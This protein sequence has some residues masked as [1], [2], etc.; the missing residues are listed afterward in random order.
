MLQ[1]RTVAGSWRKETR[2]K[3]TEPRDAEPPKLAELALPGIQDSE[4]PYSP[5]DSDTAWPGWSEAED[6][7]KESESKEFRT[8]EERERVVQY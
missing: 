3:P 7:E 8:K 4:P 2:L 1:S 6:E 5:R